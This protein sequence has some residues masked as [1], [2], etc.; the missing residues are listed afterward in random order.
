MDLAGDDD[1]PEL[2]FAPSPNRGASTSYLAPQDEDGLAE[3]V[4]EDE[5]MAEEGKEEESQPAAQPNESSPKK[6]GRP[7]K[8]GKQRGESGSSRQPR[9]PS[10]LGG[11]R[12]IERIASSRGKA[13]TVMDGDVRRSTRHRIAPLDWWRG[14]RAV[15]GRPS[16]SSRH[17]DDREG[18]N[19][20]DT[21]DA[22]AFEDSPVK[23]YGVPVLKSVIRVARAPGEGT[24]AGMRIT[25]KSSGNGRVKGKR[26][27]RAKGETPEDGEEVEIELDPEAPSRHPEDGWDDNTEAHGVVWDVEQQ[28]EVRRRVVCPITQ[29][30]TTQAANSTFAFEKIFSVDDYMAGGILEIA[31]D[32]EKPLKPTKDNNYVFVVLEGAIDV[33]IYRTYYRL[34]PGGTFTVPK[35]NTYAVRNISRRTARIFFAQSRVPQK[36][37]P[38]SSV[39]GTSAAA[40]TNN[41]SASQS[42]DTPVPTSQGRSKTHTRADE[43][44]D[45]PDESQEGIA[46]KNGKSKGRG[47]PKKTAAAAPADDSITPHVNGH[48]DDSTAQDTSTSSVTPLKR[49]RGRPKKNP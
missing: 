26:R 45:V 23:S 35:G 30:R 42:Q 8:N 2:P 3:G 49:K 37:T 13:G 24:F 40:S 19:P 16:S 9:L 5:H 46:S 15:Y 6:R 27:K 21:V 20:D 48:G 22:D 10:E 36:T 28:A 12:I 44:V 34:A 32:G 1:Y 11:D 29:L 31:P 7:R 33:Q 17:S 47:R 4:Y 43:T 18:Q 25:K 38:D 41:R 14:E 39:R